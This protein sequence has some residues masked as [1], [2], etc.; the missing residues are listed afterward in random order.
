[1]PTPIAIATSTCTYRIEYQRRRCSAMDLRGAAAAW[2]SRRGGRRP[3]NYRPSAEHR[4]LHHRLL[5]CQLLHQALGRRQRHSQGDDAKHRHLRSSDCAGVWRRVGS[6][7]AGGLCRRLIR[8]G[9]RPVGPC[10]LSAM[11]AELPQRPL[12]IGMGPGLIRCISSTAWSDR[13]LASLGIDVLCLGRLLPVTYSLSSLSRGFPSLLSAPAH[14]TSDERIIIPLRIVFTM[15]PPY[16][17]SVTPP[18]H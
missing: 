13:V 16:S 3:L 9:A 12:P 2:R 10:V 14:A 18:G 17:S 7:Q 15:I 1:M 6:G 11:P 8:L 5:R 4:H